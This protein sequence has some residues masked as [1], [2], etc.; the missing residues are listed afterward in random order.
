MLQDLPAELQQLV[1]ENIGMYMLKSCFVRDII[2]GQRQTP[3]LAKNRIILWWKIMSRYRRLSAYIARKL[4]SI[5]QGFYYV[6]KNCIYYAPYLPCSTCR[7]CNNYRQ[8]HMFSTRLI[9]QFYLN[10]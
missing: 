6:K 3:Y 2:Y 9:E 1:V 7:F 4:K 5:S 8:D 10:M